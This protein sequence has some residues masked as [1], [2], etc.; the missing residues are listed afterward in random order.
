MSDFLQNLAEQRYPIEDMYCGPVRQEKYNDIIYYRRRI[1]I[2]GYT[3]CQQ[4]VVAEKDKEIDRLKK[5]LEDTFK[6]DAFF[7]DEHSENK[8]DAWK[9]FAQENKI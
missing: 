8:Y 4:T 7:D 9:T 1:F 3:E 2:E 6:N 5:L